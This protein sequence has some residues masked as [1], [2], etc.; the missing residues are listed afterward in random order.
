MVW[1]SL[2]MDIHHHAGILRAYHQ[3]LTHLHHARLA[4]STRAHQKNLNVSRCIPLFLFHLS[5]KAALPC[6]VTKKTPCD[7]SRSVF[8][9]D[10]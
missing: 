7:L 4:T 3:Q 5:L 9:F 10:S 1:K 8:A 6:R 2:N